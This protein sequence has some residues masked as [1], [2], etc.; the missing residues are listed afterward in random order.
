MS[1]RQR[2][3][4]VVIRNGVQLFV[5][6]HATMPEDYTEADVHAAVVWAWHARSFGQPKEL[7]D[8]IKNGDYE[9]V[10]QK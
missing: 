9:Y 10:V 7:R 4:I 5:T 2:L 3:E 8:A 6:K 1:G